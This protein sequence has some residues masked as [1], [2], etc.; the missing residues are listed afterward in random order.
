MCRQSSDGYYADTGASLVVS[1]RGPGLDKLLDAT[2]AALS[3][4][5]RGEGG[6]SINGI[7]RTVHAEAKKRGYNVIYDLTGHGIGRGCTKARGHPELL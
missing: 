7:G 1:R 3:K 2:K 6:K 5:L 4:A